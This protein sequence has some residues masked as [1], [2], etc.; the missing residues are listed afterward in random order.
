M[1]FS[2]ITAVYNRAALIGGA[3][4]SVRTQQGARVQQVIIDGG[5]TDG[6]LDVIR[7]R[8]T[9]D[10]VLVS[11][12]DEG[13][14]D[15]LNKGLRL[16]DG[17]VVGFM[18]SDDFFADEHV[19]SDV[20]H[21][22]E[23]R[24]V[25]AVYGDLEYVARENSSQVIRR[26]RAG[27][28]SRTALARGWMPPHPTLFV[29]RAVITRWGG[30]DP[31]FRISGDYDAVLRYFA[32]GEIRVAYL[33]RVLVKMRM[34]GESNKSIRRI[35]TKSQEDYVALRRNQVGGMGALI[36]KNLSKVGQFWVW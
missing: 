22:F 15:A 13:I 4:D 26:W 5:S 9:E 35:L 8:M 32:R 2:I 31:A 21:A 19:L 33:P 14:Y 16:A 1:K 10:V 18:H 20:L 3:L 7:T 36:W 27:P 29:R 28:Y 11:E 17:D 24:G 23:T 34:G 6:T 30:F 25:D 12:P